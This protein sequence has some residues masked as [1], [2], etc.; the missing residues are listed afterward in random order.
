MKSI[1]SQR[2]VRAVLLFAVAVAVAGVSYAATPAPTVMLSGRYEK[3]KGFFPAQCQRTER[4]Y[5]CH[6]HTV[7]TPCESHPYGQPHG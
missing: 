6:E 2:F 7:W 5:Y 3:C 4:D 1:L